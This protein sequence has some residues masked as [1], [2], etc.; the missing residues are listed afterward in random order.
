MKRILAGILLVTALA[1]C[2]QEDP[3][4][5]PECREWQQTY[6]RNVQMIPDLAPYQL[7]RRPDGCDIPQIPT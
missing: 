2:N 5:S 6:M 4:D 7:E 1:A 3:N